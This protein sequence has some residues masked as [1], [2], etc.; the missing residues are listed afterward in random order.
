MNA[1]PS[2]QSDA[3]VAERLA[4]LERVMNAQQKQI[5]WLRSE[6]NEE[7]RARQKLEIQVFGKTT[8]GSSSIQ[9]AKKTG[10]RLE[11]SAS[12]SE[13]NDDFA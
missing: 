3:D 1:P 5:A 11:R 10:S 7:K 8:E 6:L 2:P 13:I 4:R 9:P 12:L